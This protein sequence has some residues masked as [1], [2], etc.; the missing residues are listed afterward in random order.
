VGFSLTDVSKATGISL[1]YLSQL[2]HNKSF[3][4]PK[5]RKKLL[6]FFKCTFYDIFEEI[7]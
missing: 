1:S 3:P 6:D 2:E 4:R 7:N 5:H